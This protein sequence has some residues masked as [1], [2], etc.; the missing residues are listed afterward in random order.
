VSLHREDA[1]CP[2]CPDP[3]TA[4]RIEDVGMKFD[5]GDLSDEGIRF[6]VT[7]LVWEPVMLEHLRLTDDDEHRHLYDRCVTALMAAGVSAEESARNSVRS[8]VDS[9]RRS[10]DDAMRQLS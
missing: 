5:S 2:A 1:Y 7:R 6:K 4:F 9:V 3:E 10:M 8:A